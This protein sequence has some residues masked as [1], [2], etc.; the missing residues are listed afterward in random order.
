MNWI[1]SEATAV[2]AVVQ[3]PQIEEGGT[4]DEVSDGSG[5]AAFPRSTSHREDRILPILGATFLPCTTKLTGSFCRDPAA[6][7][8]EYE[9]SAADPT[10]RLRG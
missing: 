1:K 3:E 7:G 9:C 5:T 8:E 4:A 6:D 2:D 10:L